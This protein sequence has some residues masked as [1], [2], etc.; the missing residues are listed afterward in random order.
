MNEQ[1]LIKLGLEYGILNYIE[2][3]TPRNYF[4]HG[5]LEEFEQDELLFFIE[6]LY[7]RIGIV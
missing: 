7:R 5:D 1:E 3:E 4:I 2:H 6:E